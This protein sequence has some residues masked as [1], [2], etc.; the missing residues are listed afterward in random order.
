MCVDDSHLNQLSFLAGFLLFRRFCPSSLSVGL[1]VKICKAPDVKV[2]LIK[3]I[4]SGLSC[5]LPFSDIKDL[6]N[7]KIGQVSCGLSIIKGKMEGE[8]TIGFFLF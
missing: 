8:Q 5:Y 7:N 4:K 3:M 2:A 6:G 1:F